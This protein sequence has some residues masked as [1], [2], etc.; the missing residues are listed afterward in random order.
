MLL[1]R[2]RRVQRHGSIPR[3]KPCYVREDIAL[4]LEELV[5]REVKKVQVG[6]QSHQLTR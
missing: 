6:W 3:Q 2:A 5:E 1:T 4:V